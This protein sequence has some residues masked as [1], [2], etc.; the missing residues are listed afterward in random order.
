MPNNAG[1]GVA[2]T[3]SGPGALG[4]PTETILIDDPDQSIIYSGFGWETVVNMR[5]SKGPHVP[6]KLPEIDVHLR[7]TALECGISPIPVPV[8]L[9]ETIN[10]A[11]V[12]NAERTQ[13]LVWSKT[14][15]NSGLHV[16]TLTHAGSSGSAMSANF[17]KYLPSNGSESS[18]ATTPVVPS[19]TSVS[20]VVFTPPP[21]SAQA[22][23]VVTSTIS[24]LSSS[25][26]KAV[27]TPWVT[28]SLL[29]IT[30]AVAMAA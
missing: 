6:P 7:S 16:V 20:I 24:S 5:T 2:P 25:T 19:P 29:Y 22:S 9:F 12:S 26:A 13:R 28:I 3:N 23:E 4:I 11:P 14:G 27:T 10:T 17:F 15:L 8:T 21:T 18:V 1:D 30:M